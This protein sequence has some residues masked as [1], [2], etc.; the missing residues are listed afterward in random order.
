MQRIFGFDIG[1][2]SIGFAVIDFGKERKAGKILRLGARIFPEARDPDGTPLNQQRRAKRMMRRQLRRRR[3]RRRSLNELLSSFGLLPPFGGKEWDEIMKLDPYAL[4]TRALG[5]LLE[6]FELGRTLYHLAKRRHF[7]ERD[8]AETGETEA[9]EAPVAEEAPSKR[10]KGISKQKAEKEQEVADEAK[11]AE[12]RAHFTAEVKASGQTI[13]A[14]L[15]Q[16]KRDAV[17]RGERESDVKLRGEHATRALVEDEFEKILAAQEAH[18]PVLKDSALKGALHEAIFAQ[19]PV[20]WRKKTLG[21]CRFMPESPLCPRGSWISQERRMLEKVNNLEFLGGNAR[22]LDAEERSALI[23]ALRVKPKL[24]WAQARKIL[25]PQFE[26]RGESARALKF[27]HE[28][29]KDQAA[30]LKGNLVDVELN[31][32]FGAAWANHPRRQELREFLPEAL[33]RADYGEIGDQRVVIRSAQKR[34]EQRREVA[35]RLAAEFAVNHEIAASLSQ[36]HFPQGWE[37]YSTEALRIMLPE[38]EEGTRFGAL[39]NGPDWAGWRDEYFPEREQPTGQFLDLLPSPRADRHASTPQEEEAERISRV[40]NPTVVRVQNELRKVVNNLIREYGKPDLIRIEL[41]RDVGKSKREREE[42]QKGMRDR[43]RLREKARKDLKEKGIADPNDDDVEKWLLWR[44]CGEECPYT[45]ARIAFADLFGGNPAFEVEH[46]WPRSQSLD[47][48]LRNKTLC[49]KRANRDKGARIPFQYFRDRPDAWAAAKDRIWKLVAKGGMT[50]GKAKRFCAES[51]PD[52]FAGRQL[53]DTSYAAREAR[54]FLERLW[55]D[56]E[57]KGSEIN[58]RPV[59]GKVTAQL[60]RRWGLNHILADDGEKTREDHRHHA[61]DALVV[62]C[63]DNGNTQRLSEYFAKEWDARHYGTPRPEAALVPEPWP[64]I[65]EDAKRAVDQ[66]IVS[67]RVRKKVSGPLHKE[68]SYGDTGVDVTNSNGTYRLFVSRKPL[69]SLS[70]SELG[71]IRDEGARR[72]VEDWVEARGGDPKKAFAAFPLRGPDGPEI[73][74]A[75]LIAPQKLR[76]MAPLKNGYATTGNNHHIAIYRLPDGKI[77]GRVVSLYEAAKRMAR[78][79]PVI[80]RQSYE[81]GAFLMSLSLGDTFFVPSGERVGYWVVNSIA[82]NGQM[83][84]RPINDAG[85]D[86][87]SQWGPSPGPLV[88]LGAK[89]ISVDPIGRVRPA[90]D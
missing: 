4:R 75:R 28:T 30:G 77:E 81:R 9:P 25:E 74:K 20:F 76:G 44:E 45:G 12:A 69:A 26:K 24:T 14:F 21:K 11:A 50:K 52:D 37:P 22:P 58:V 73:K 83:F 6:T 15:S 61:V 86:S 17:L 47:N 5:E 19:R 68:T 89:K 8:I 65:R 56:V 34:A 23:E 55:P 41:A 18:H 87:K 38:L 1:T 62:A 48:S 84:S 16:R 59:T 42:M 63:A 72:I 85:K 90:N 10:R 67:H 53:N 82:G 35:A 51:M 36:L 57:I 80:S 29:D 31:K 70:K 7:K 43:E 54:A 79:E 71:D 32:A 64:T 78:H 88:K 3:E 33:W 40:R 46:I 27:N 13:G 2:T 66:I 60:R 39:L 49:E